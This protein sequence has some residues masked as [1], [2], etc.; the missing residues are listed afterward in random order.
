M[1]N[2]LKLQLLNSILKYDF[3]FV[4]TILSFKLENNRYFSK[5]FVLKNTNKLDSYF[6]NILELIKNLK[7]IIR[8]LQF[9]K[10]RNCLNLKFK[11]TFSLEFLS[12]LLEKNKN[13]LKKIY[14]NK[15]ENI[16]LHKSLQFYC[17]IDF[18]LNK[19]LSKKLLNNDKFLIAEINT[20]F[21][22]EDIGFYKLFNQFK[23]FQKIV[24]FSILLKNIFNK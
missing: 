6:L 11:K 19:E 21:K 15:K 17:F 3:F 2:S 12:F 5:K 18:T 14:F 7:Q 23:N 4:E 9:I 22:N 13:I 16:N 20:S 8:I 24:F 1:V 10:K